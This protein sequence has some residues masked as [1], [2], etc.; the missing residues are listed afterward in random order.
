MKKILCL[1][2]SIIILIASV[3]LFTACDLLDAFINTGTVPP[4][5]EPT[6]CMHAY[7]ISESEA[8][9]TS[10][11]YIT[12]KCSFCGDSYRKYEN[13]LGHTTTQGTC[14]RCGE[15]FG[16][17]EA[18]YYVDEFNMPTSVPYMRNSE[19]FVGTFSNSATTDSLL[20]ARI[21]IDADDV[22]I[23]LWEY[24]RSE[25]KAYT[26]T[27]YKLTFLTDNGSKYNT[28]GTMYKNGDRIFLSDYNA[29][30][31]LLKNNTTIKIYIQENSKYGVNSTY[32]F[33]INA[34]N[35]NEV[36]YKLQNG[37]VA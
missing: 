34:G 8:T 2:F 23:L 32:L 35:F 25:V 1:L 12:Y 20:Y 15:T 3:T 31:K 27:N 33:T 36:Y 10:G 7:S 17:W 26:S 22:S 4:T 5:V 18:N 14:S 21:L 29:L 37:I 24:G 11:G 28:T 9:C 13:A 6:P 19:L 16:T 30:I